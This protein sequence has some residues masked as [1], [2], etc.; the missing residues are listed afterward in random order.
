LG[1]SKVMIAYTL[2]MITDVWGDV[3]FTE[4][5]QGEKGILTPKYDSQEQLYQNI[6]KLLAEAIVHLGETT[7]SGVPA[8]GKS[9]LIFGG[10]ASKWIAVAKSLQVRYALHLSLKNGYGAVR[11]VINSGGLIA[12]NTGDFQLNFGTTANENNPRFQFDLQRSDIRVGAR[13]VNLM[14][15]TGDPRRSVYFNPKGASDYTGSEPGAARLAAAWIGPAYAD[16][17]APVYFLNY[18][19]LKFIEAE[20]FFDTDKA[21]AADAF[22]EGV[23]VSLSKLGVSD[24]S[25]EA[26]NAAET[27]TSITFGKI[28]T[29]KYISLFMSP[30]AWIDW[31]RTGLPSL[32]GPVGGVSEMPRRYLYPTDERLFNSRNL[33]NGILSTDRVWWDQ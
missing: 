26:V 14:N 3:P 21:R 1:I 19:E 18:F 25:W 12:G 2:A 7:P 16:K 32:S 6:D 24:E 33:P 9:D 5:L 13:V 11:D 27:A 22:N 30:E 10:D 4:A 31:R 17:R 8:P 23:K 28:M 20:A 29:G 15:A